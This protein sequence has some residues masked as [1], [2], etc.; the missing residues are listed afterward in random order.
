MLMAGD[1]VCLIITSSS[2]FLGL[3]FYELFGNEDG[4]FL[5]GFYVGFCLVF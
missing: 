4:A 1:L 2:E 5:Y 3:C